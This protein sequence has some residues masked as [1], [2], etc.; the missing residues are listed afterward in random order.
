MAILEAQREEAEAQQLIRELLG[1]GRRGPCG[2][3]VRVAPKEMRGTA[4]CACC[5]NTDVSFCCSE[6]GNCSFRACRRC[7]LGDIR[8]QRQRTAAAAAERAESGSFGKEV[9]ELSEEVVASREEAVE[10][11]STVSGVR[12]GGEGRLGV[13]VLLF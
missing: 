3:A 11:E 6:L 12:A 10:G 1:S 8:V 13:L 4:S 2:H 5:G 9:V 7:L